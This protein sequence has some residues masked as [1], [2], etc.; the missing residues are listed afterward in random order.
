MKAFNYLAPSGFYN[1]LKAYRFPDVFSDLDRA[2]QK[3]TK[4]YICTTYG[5]TGPIIVDGLTKQGG[6]LSPVK[7]TLTTSL[8]H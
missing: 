6:P 1:A 3:Q 7:S 5:I 2:G 8:G 4:A